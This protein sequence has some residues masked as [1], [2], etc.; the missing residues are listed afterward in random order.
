MRKI[1][2]SLLAL[3]GAIPVVAAAPSTD[4]FAVVGARVFDGRQFIPQATVI[5][6][7]GRIAA[8][9]GGLEVPRDMTVFD[10][11]GRTLL[12]GLIDAHTHSFENARA[13]ALRFGVTTEL[14]MFTDHRLLAAARTAREGFGPRS[15]ADLFSAG[16]LVTAPGGHGTEYGL[17][18]PTLSRAQDAA[19]FVDA[20][21]AEGSDYI[22][23]VYD[24]GRNWGRAI[25]TLDH[26][27]LATVI[28]AAHRRGKLALVHV[29]D[30]Q[31]ALASVQAGADGLLHAFGP[32]DD[33][34]LQLARKYKVFVVPTLGVMEG[35]SGTEDRAEL[36]ND[37]HISA[38]LHRTATKALLAAFGAPR[39]EMFR[40]V[41]EAVRRMHRAGM[42]LLAGT[43]ASNPGVVHGASLHREL[44]LLTQAGLTPAQALAA[45][46]ALPAERFGLADRGRIAPGLRAD[47]VLVSG[48]PEK[49]IR[50]TRAIEA[51]WKNGHHVDRK[52]AA[53]AAA[54]TPAASGDL[55]SDFEGTSITARFGY[56][57]ERSTDQVAGGH[58]EAAHERV[59]AGARGS[60]GALRVSGTIKDGFNWPWAGVAFYPGA[61]PMQAVNLASK[62]ELVFWVRGDGG[63]YR[64]MIM[65]DGDRMPA[66]AAFTAGPDWREVRIPVKAFRAWPMG[67]AEMD[68]LQAIMFCAGKGRAGFAFEIDDVA[69]R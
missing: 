69:L 43:D 15:E 14:D 50:A 23:I 25:P 38:Y 29:S 7:E 54:A 19:A 41:L 33:A 56:G 5:V 31:A 3:V 30:P 57:W 44:L 59:A 27:T 55:I 9:G 53:V 17:P 45:A 46:T 42:P 62:T 4:S 39:P 34:F 1:L 64:A 12:P 52:P 37:P 32:V 35:L 16:T 11:R 28:T 18:I 48:D 61:A 22:K 60:G 36:A 6:R 63:S 65:S 49:D 2:L 10:G 66:E 24:D 47:L 13:D 20:R 40:S 58:S 21:L 51:I 26:S 67:G 68:Q 8:V